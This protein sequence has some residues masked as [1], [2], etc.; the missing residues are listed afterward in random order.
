M[1][2]RTLI[3]FIVVESIFFAYSAEALELIPY[4]SHV[5]VKSGQLHL[6][7]GLFIDYSDDLA[8]E[9]RF[10]ERI[11]S[12]F[13]IPVT[14]GPKTAKI[15]LELDR[16]L[17]GKLGLEG[18]QLFVGK[19]GI[20]IKSASNAGIFYGIQ[21]FRQLI[22]KNP[23]S[24]QRV[25]IEDKPRYPWRAF[26]LDEGRYFKGMDAVKQ[27]LD[28]M[29]RLKMNTFHWHLTDDQG[30]RIEIKKY[31][32]LTEIG[33]KRD[34]TQTGIWPSGWKSTIFDGVPHEGFYT[35][36]QIK[37]IVQY[38]EERHI[39]IIP[40]IEMPG[41]ASAAIAAY[42]WLGT[43]KKQIKVPVQFGVSND[44]FN[45]ADSKVEGFL[46]DVLD[47]IIEL[48]PSPVIHIGGDEVKYDHWKNSREINDFMETNSISSYADLQLWFT[49]KIS[50][51]IEKKGRRMMGWNEIMG[52]PL[53]DYS[54]K[55]IVVRGSLAPNAII[56]FWKG[57]IELINDAILKGHDIVN[58]YHEYT[59]LDYDYNTIPLSKAYDFNPTPDNIPQIHR[60]KILG[61]GCQMWGEWIPTVKS[62]HILVFPRL[63][64]YAEVGWT[65][66]SNK[67]YERFLRGLDLLN[68]KW[69]K[70]GIL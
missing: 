53:H 21:T 3:I 10:L 33:S 42:P 65:E 23:A 35:Q 9:T 41:H 44:V 31:P 2:I 5:K 68:Q 14:N 58:S 69:E 66:A 20:V 39:T 28:E 60:G 55:E 17:N 40:E 37:E 24:I 18:Y 32:L 26:L 36:D 30:W 62:M 70:A 67:D 13:D 7:D 43:V 22:S 6:S 56:H 4:P 63:A 38:A 54:E 49:N 52:T 50:N 48:F 47:E 45:V 12:E 29:A 61:S 19:K 34:S 15:K 25:E 46:K 27:L 16:S 11:L 59:Y 51:Y 1:K 64:A 8:V 57:D